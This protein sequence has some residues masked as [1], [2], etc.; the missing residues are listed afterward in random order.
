MDSC[1]PESSRFE[2][3]QNGNIAFLGLQTGV[4]AIEAPE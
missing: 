2:R 4:G 1:K 3:G